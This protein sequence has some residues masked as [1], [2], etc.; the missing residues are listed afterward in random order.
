[1]T[2]T[3]E[4]LFTYKRAKSPTPIEKSQNDKLPDG[5][6]T[7]YFSQPN[8]ISIAPFAILDLEKGL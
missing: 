5:S 3:N 4:N 8:A 7:D 6:G 1:M 2:L